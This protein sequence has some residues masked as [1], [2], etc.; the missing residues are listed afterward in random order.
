MELGRF[1]EGVRIASRAASIAP[2]D[3]WILTNLAWLQQR[4]GFWDLSAH[5]A[6]R[7]IALD[8]E[9]EWPHRLRGLAL[10][11]LG[12]W[13]DAVDAMRE[14]IRLTPDQYLPYAVF[15]QYA[16][17]VGCADEGLEM[18]ERAV[19]LAPDE[20]Y[21]WFGLGWSAFGARRWD[22]AERALTKARD[23]TPASSNP[24]NNL[25]ALYLRLDRVDEA[26][27]CFR[28]ALAIDARSEYAYLNSACAL[29]KLGDWVAAQDLAYRFYMRRLD[30]AE[31]RIEATKTPYAFVTRGFAR[32]RLG[33]FDDGREDFAHALSLASDP[34]ERLIALCPLLRATLRLGNREVAV[35]LAE[36]LLEEHPA[37]SRALGI[38]SLAA[39]VVDDADLAR[40]AAALVG[41][42]GNT[43]AQRGVEGDLALVTKDWRT[44]ISR[45]SV[46]I[47]TRWQCC[48]EA[49]LAVAQ[50]QA[51]DGEGAKAAVTEAVCIDPNCDTLALAR[52]WH[53][54]PVEQL[55]PAGAVEHLHRG[56]SPRRD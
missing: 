37:E 31:T 4:A 40:R 54:F 15:A 53:D 43:L 2:Q 11:Q 16:A 19:E 55:A 47:E 39:W 51:G 1:E 3:R 42:V 28:R 13:D 8:P 20:T 17:S 24:H 49:S 6:E 27:E 35:R 5:T 32:C 23:L 50:W 10:Y 46:R 22:V 25:G 9:Y 41:A 21:A 34:H 7:S 45:F 44:A 18:G 36:R 29:R 26:L 38:V 48:V 12:R 56:P 52:R 30:E 14:A 33:H